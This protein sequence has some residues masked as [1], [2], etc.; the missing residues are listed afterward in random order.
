[1]HCPSLS[2]SSRQTKH[3]HPIGTRRGFVCKRMA[4]AGLSSSGDFAVN[5]ACVGRNS[6]KSRNVFQVGTFCVKRLGESGYKA[7]WVD[8]LTGSWHIFVAPLGKF[9]LLFRLSFNRE[10]AGTVVVRRV[11][12]SSESSLALSVD[13]VP[14]PVIFDGCC[15]PLKAVP[16]PFRGCDGGE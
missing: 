10:L 11:L 3:A 12:L 13:D 1:M 14:L 7:S 4:G 8:M 15:Y 6:A 5:A 9:L 16:N 2:P